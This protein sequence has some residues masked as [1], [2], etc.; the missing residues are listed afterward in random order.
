VRHDA[1]DFQI[2]ADPGTRKIDV[3]LDFDLSILYSAAM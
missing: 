1:S 3:A 2:N